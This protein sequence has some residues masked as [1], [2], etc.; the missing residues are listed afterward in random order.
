MPQ[1]SIDL[2]ADL[3]EGE[4][5]EA[6]LLT[7]VSSCNVACGGHTGDPESMARTVRLANE[8]G[9]SVGAHPSY[10]DREGFGRR[11]RFLQGDELLASLT[12][13][14]ASLAVVCAELGVDLKTLKPHGALYNDARNDEELAGLLARLA[15]ERELTLVGMPDSAT[16]EAA[17]RL[18]V[19]YLREGFVDRAY[20]ADGSLCPRSREGALIEDVTVAAEQARRLAEG[21]TV[22]TAEGGELKLE[23]DTL[24]LHGDTPNAADT[25]N[26]VQSALQN[27]GISIVPSQYG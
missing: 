12:E 13:Q 26:A 16:Q 5:S 24:C 27:A 14:L 10:P 25:A 7:V 2:N 3:G 11:S 23:V 1:S 9:V 18:Q 21:R 4:A 20:L 17:E 8:H 15:G 19:P 6:L 22:T